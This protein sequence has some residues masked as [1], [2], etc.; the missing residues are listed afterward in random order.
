M[1]VADT[2]TNLRKIREE[3]LGASRE[4]VLRRTHS[5]SLGTVRNAEMGKRVKRVKACQLLTAINEMLIERG[6]QTVKMND[7]GLEVY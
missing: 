5:V 3:V 1:E 2:A 4:D 6:R 7:L